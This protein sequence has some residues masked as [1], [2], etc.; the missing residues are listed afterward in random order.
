VPLGLFTA[1][2]VWQRL[3]VGYVLAAVLV[4][5]GAAMGAGIAA[6][7]IVEFLVTDDLQIV[8]IA[9]F[10]AISAVSIA[11]AS[12]VYGSIAALPHLA[13]TPTTGT[14]AHRAARG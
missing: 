14:M 10:A 2:T 1:A 3:P 8:P 4:V 5:K 7:L 11:L 6:M 13:G 9:L 12:R